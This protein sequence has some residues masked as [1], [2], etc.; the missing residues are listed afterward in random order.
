MS[1]R[2]A[3]PSLRYGASG[4][5]TKLYEA[6]RVITVSVAT[7]KTKIFVSNLSLPELSIEHLL[8][9]QQTRTFHQLVKGSGLNALVHLT[10][11]EP[12]SL[13]TYGPEPYVFAS[14][15][16]GAFKF[17]TNEIIP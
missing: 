2:V 6:K 11:L 17:C 14:F 7:A 5:K 10:G 12:A 1:H 8:R 13:T 3:P 16:T 4:L 15:T 9:K